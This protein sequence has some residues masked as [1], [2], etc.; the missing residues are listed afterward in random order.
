MGLLWVVSSVL[1]GNFVLYLLIV[2]SRNYETKFW[3]HLHCGVDSEC[4]LN[5]NLKYTGESF[6]NCMS[7]KLISAT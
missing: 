4:A 3:N 2:F 5:M 7:F 6:F 1:E